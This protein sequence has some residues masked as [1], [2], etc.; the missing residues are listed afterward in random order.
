MKKIDRAT[1]FAKRDHIYISYL[2]GSMEKFFLFSS[3]KENVII[4]NEMKAVYI[5]D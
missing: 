1:Q 2:F 4:K 3:D 5:P